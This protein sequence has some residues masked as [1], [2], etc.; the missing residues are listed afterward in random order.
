MRS[1]LIMASFRQSHLNCAYRLVCTARP[2]PSMTNRSTPT[3]ASASALGTL[4]RSR[5]GPPCPLATTYSRGVRSKPAAAAAGGVG[6]VPAT[7]SPG[8]PLLLMK[9]GPGLQPPPAIAVKLRL[10]L[11]LAEL[12]RCSRAPP[13][14]GLW[15]GSPGAPLPSVSPARLLLGG[16]PTSCLLLLLPPCARGSPAAGGDLHRQ[17][18]SRVVHHLCW[19]TCA[20]G[21]TEGHANWVASTRC[22]QGVAG[23]T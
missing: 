9:L 3:V 20:V 1:V 17:H 22:M 8:A 14:G 6:G 12:R 23:T 21:H 16:L 15:L 4:L 19:Y 2:M 10:L 11:V 7:P 18:N 13:V 5:Q